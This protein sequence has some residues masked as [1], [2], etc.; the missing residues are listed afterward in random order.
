[1]D[2][3]HDLTTNQRNL[4]LAGLD[5]DSSGNGGVNER[6][7]TVEEGIIQKGTYTL[8]VERA[9]ARMAAAEEQQRALGCDGLAAAIAGRRRGI[10]DLARRLKRQIARE[11]GVLSA[12]VDGR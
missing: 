1:M 8:A 6:L 10:E 4:L 11:G 7:R 3:S 2:W 12:N 9:G 5:S